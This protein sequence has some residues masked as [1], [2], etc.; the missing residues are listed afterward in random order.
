MQLHYLLFDFSDEES[1]SGSFDAMACVASHHVAAMTAEAQA[2][3]AWAESVFGPAAPLEEGGEWDHALAQS[4]EGSLTTLTLT[5][6][7]TPAFCKAFHST[8]QSL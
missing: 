5:L 4:Q 6:S 1:G 7:G 2:V 8:F 3:L